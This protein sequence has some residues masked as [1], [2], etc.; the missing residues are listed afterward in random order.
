MAAITAE[1][2][3]ELVVARRHARWAAA[4]GGVEYGRGHYP[5][6]VA[7]H[8]GLIVGTL[9][10]VALGHRAF[11]PMVGWP[12]LA[13]VVLANAA[14]WWC[15]RSLGP[16]WNTRVIIVPG[17]P[18]VSSGPYRWV[19]HPNYVVVIAEGLA[20]PLVYGAWLT[21]LLFTLANAALLM[22][23]TRVENKALELVA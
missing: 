9:A 23:R 2:L 3:F 20:L 4:R 8:I 11:V 10:E 22:V 12:A 6:M 21:A 5:V 17:L 15:I 7:L 16:Q 18:L 19:R 1:R 14:R 13:G